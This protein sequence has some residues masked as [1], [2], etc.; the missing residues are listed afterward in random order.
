RHRPGAGRG[1]RAVYVHHRHHGAVLP[2][3]RTDHRRFD[4]DLGVQLV[5]A[6]PGPVGAA[7]QAAREGPFRAAPVVGLR[8]VWRLGG[9]QT[10]LAL[11]RT[12]TGRPGPE[13]VAGATG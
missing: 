5:D 1:V 2:T 10:R 9:P 6:K 13:P 11:R 12:G 4:R 3:V 8:A 7:A